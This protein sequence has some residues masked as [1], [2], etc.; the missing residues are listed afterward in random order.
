MGLCND[1]MGASSVELRAHKAKEVPYALGRKWMQAFSPFSHKSPTN[2]PVSRSNL[3]ERN[4]IEY[5]PWQAVLQMCC[6]DIV[7]NGEKME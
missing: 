7:Y 4:I 1:L 5:L 2:F 6:G 3:E